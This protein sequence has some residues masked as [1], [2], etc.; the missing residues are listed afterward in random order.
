MGIKEACGIGVAGA[1]GVDSRRRPGL[2]IVALVAGLD[3]TAI[4]ADLDD[5]NPAMPGN[6]CV[7]SEERETKLYQIIET[8]TDSESQT[9]RC[10]CEDSGLQLL[11]FRAAPLKATSEKTAEWYFAQT[12]IYAGSVFGLKAYVDKMLSSGSFKRPGE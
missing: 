3:P 1:R 6:L 2:D 9:I 4:L 10:T 11:G 5:R 7:R 8:T 12:L